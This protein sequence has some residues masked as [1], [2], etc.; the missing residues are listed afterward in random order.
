MC[1][2][3]ATS[4]VSG[5][6]INFPGSIN[7]NESFNVEINQDS[8]NNYD[9]KIFIH[10]STDEKISRN[11]I[12]SHILDEG[13]WKDSYLYIN[14]AYPKKNVYSIKADS[15]SS[16]ANICVQLRISGKTTI[17]EKECQPIQ[18]EQIIQKEAISAYPENFT[19]SLVNNSIISL[20][21]E[22]SKIYLSSPKEEKYIYYSQ[23]I[24]KER[25]ILYSFIFLLIITAILLINGKL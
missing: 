19:V 25:I 22:S 1:I 13:K 21:N 23:E 5:L 2:L 24:I 8:N 11:E 16:N 20:K 7:V 18:I 17:S 9:I 15:Y 10:N 4:L 6:D 14:N 12:I 3:T